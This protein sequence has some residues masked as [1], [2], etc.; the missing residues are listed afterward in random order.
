VQ[1]D[2][3]CELGQLQFQDGIREARRYLTI[4]EGIRE[5]TLI[6]EEALLEGVR[7]A[8]GERPARVTREIASLSVS[9]TEE[10]LAAPGVLYRILQALALQG[11]NLAEVASTTTELHLYLAEDDVMLALDSLYGAFR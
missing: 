1:L 7:A 11:V 3:G 9:L 8:V 4:T 2:A 5:I 10:N 6:T